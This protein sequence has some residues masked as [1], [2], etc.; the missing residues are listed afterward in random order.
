MIGGWNSNSPNNDDDDDGSTYC[1]ICGPL[2][3]YCVYGL[4]FNIVKYEYIWRV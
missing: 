2:C 1:L 4:R 3:A